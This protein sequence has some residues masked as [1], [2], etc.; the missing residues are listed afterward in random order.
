VK[1]TSL[2]GRKFGK[3]TI[4]SV[5]RK[6][7]KWRHISVRCRCSCGKRV[8]VLTHN[9]TSGGTRSCGHLRIAIWKV[10][11]KKNVGLNVRHGHA[12]ARAHSPT[13]VSF[14]MAKNRCNNPNAAD[15]ARYGGRGI[16]FC[17]KSFE[18]FVAE[19][20]IRPRGKSVD[21]IDNDGDY[22]AGNV[23]WSTPIEQAANRR[24]R[25]AA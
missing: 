5:S 25:A 13:Y 17:F 2:K 3:L 6:R 16:R 20:G 11:G 21:R 15:W 12:R 7:N 4:L 23:K 8:T 24:V 14:A 19:L 10:L 22:R 18:A 1:A 9:V